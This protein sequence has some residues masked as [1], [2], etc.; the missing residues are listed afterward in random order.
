MSRYTYECDKCGIIEVTMSYKDLPLK[1]CPYCKSANVERVWFNTSQV[2]STEGA[3]SHP[4]VK[5]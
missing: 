2:W 1:E 4:N 5:E 3:Y